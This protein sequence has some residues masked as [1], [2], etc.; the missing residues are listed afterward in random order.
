MRDNDYEVLVAGAGPVGLALAGELA[1]RGVR[2]L[3]IERLAEPSTTIKAGGINVVTAEAAYWR[4]L[5]PQL[6]AA[7]DEGMAA[8]AKFVSSTGPWP[9]EPRPAALR[10]HFGGLWV[11]DDG[12]RLAG[13]PDFA[14]NP[15][16]GVIMVNQQAIERIFGAWAVE[17]GARVR[18][19]VA[20][21]GFDDHGDGVTVELAD[22]ERITADWLVGCDGG[23]STV[24]KLGGFDF[25]GTDPTITGHQAIVDIEGAEKLPIGWT[26]TA[27]GMLVYG[28]VPGRILTVEY[29]GPPIDRDAPITT[30]ELETSL[31]NVSGVDDLRITAV[32]SST[33]FTDHARQV[34]EYR[35][36]RVLLAGD[37][38]HVHS[39]FGG[40]GLNLGI[41]DA[42]NLGWKLAATIDGTAPEGLLDTY[43]TER[44]PVGAWVLDWNRAQ[45]AL[46]RPDVQ[47]SA[48]RAVVGDL[49]GTGDGLIYFAKKL[50][51]LWIDY[52]LGGEHPLVGRR[53]P[54]LE[55]D[56]G[57]RLGEHCADGRPV[58]VDLGDGRL[59]ELAAGWGA[60]VN[61]LVT[62]CSAHPGL[63]GL[64]VR[65]DGYVAWA[66]ETGSNGLAD[67]LT[68][69]FGVPE[70][71]T[72][73]V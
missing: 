62:T 64:L 69:W 20:L 7:Q 57:T 68:R 30:R 55:F 14:P 34:S 72:M 28:P 22:G 44:H 54:D 6:R 15:A 53:T 70:R 43:T 58:L 41:G 46:M 31:R 42:L 1:L 52:D 37:A 61:V 17:R 9:V 10:G 33:R 23:R 67:A 60:R 65:P 63:A 32:H 29:D 66:A 48:L 71:A 73:V 2:T 59:A 26:R 11:L 27:T 16:T 50:A 25:P 36:G 35:R 24:R 56:D 51:G 19:G 5:L 4:G 13:D 12:R 3:V 18:R 38:A 21:A 8:M 40:Q 45:V 49:I 39:P 47:T